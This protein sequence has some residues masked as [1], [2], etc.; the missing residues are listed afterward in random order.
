MGRIRTVSGFLKV[1]GVSD[2]H[3]ILDRT[4]EGGCLWTALVLSSTG[5]P[6]GL[7]RPYSSNRSVWTVLVDLMPM[8][9]FSWAHVDYGSSSFVLPFGDGIDFGG[10]R[11][12]VRLTDNPTQSL[13]SAT[14]IGRES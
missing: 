11:L 12:T 1:S 4:I 7:S 13:V 9:E 2:G 6:G 14:L 5:F 10:R 3:A 8:F